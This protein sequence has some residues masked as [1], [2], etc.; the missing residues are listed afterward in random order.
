MIDKSK[1]VI[2]G[3]KGMIGKNIPYGVKLDRDELDITMADSIR[4]AFDA[5]N[6]ELVIHLA[7]IKNKTYCETHVAE[8]YKINVLG[9]LN[10]AEQCR[11]RNIPMIFISSYYVFDG[12]SSTPYKEY[13]LTNPLNVYGKTKFIGE[14]IVKDFDRRN[15]IVRLGLVYGRGIEDSFIRFVAERILK[16]EPVE[17]RD[18]KRFS[19][20]NIES[21]IKGIS[22]IIE[23]N[24]SGTF[25]LAEK[26]GPSYYEVADFIREQI[27]PAA[28]VT[29]IKNV[30]DHDG[31]VS[32]G[33]GFEVLEPSEVFSSSDWKEPLRDYLLSIKR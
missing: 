12:N 28:T 24:L 22:L 1:I 5:Y 2:T 4:F 33:G 11:L 17:E 26:G 7:A 29:A 19:L 16:G 27:N 18:D 20:T 30:L 23:K 8:A 10:V 14:L 21:F 3:G 9:T 13:D 25:H 32:R 31:A 6:P 15:S